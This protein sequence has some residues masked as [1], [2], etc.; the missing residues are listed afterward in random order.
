MIEVIR[1]HLQD[2]N[3]W[4]TVIIIGLL[5]GCAANI[6][7]LCAE[8]AAQLPNPN[9]TNV[10]AKVFDVRQ[11][12]AKG[13]G[14]TL[15]TAAIQKAL[16][17]CGKAGGGIVRFPAGTYLSKPISLHSKTTLLLDEGAILKATDDVQDFLK[18]GRDLGRL[19]KRGEECLHPVHQRQ[20]SDRCHHH[21]Q[22][23]D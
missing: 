16:D 3:W 11:F 17:E 10:A 4:F 12:G 21:R 15:D 2:S 7:P 14:K 8:T 13:D 6:A 19:G 5:F 23:H 20:E 22:G 9:A 1:K 18:A